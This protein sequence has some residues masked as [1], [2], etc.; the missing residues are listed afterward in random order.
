MRRTAIIYSPEG[1]LMSPSLLARWANQ[2]HR[3]AGG[4]GDPFKTTDFGLFDTASRICGSHCDCG[5]FEGT[6]SGITAGEFELLPRDSQE[7]LEG[8]KAYMRC[9]KC[10]KLSHL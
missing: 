8:G 4:E 9:R 1:H 10:N 5:T 3:Q 7:V 6:E 2:V